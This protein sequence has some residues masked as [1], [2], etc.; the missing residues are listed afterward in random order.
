L[1]AE[2]EKRFGFYPLQWGRLMLYWLPMLRY[3][4]KHDEPMK[5]PEPSQPGEIIG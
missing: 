5:P 1:A 2:H 3:C 4:I